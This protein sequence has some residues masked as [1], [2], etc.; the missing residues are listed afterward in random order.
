MS[1]VSNGAA[2][3]GRQLHLVAGLPSSRAVEVALK[4]LGFIGF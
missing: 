1:L 3:A 4:K 2:R